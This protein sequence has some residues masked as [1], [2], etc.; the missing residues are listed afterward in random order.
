MKK[1]NYALQW[2]LW[3]D[4]TYYKASCIKDVVHN[5]N[6]L[7]CLIYNKS[8]N[9]CDT[10]CLSLA[11]KDLHV[12]DRQRENNGKCQLI[13]ANNVSTL[14]EKRDLLACLNK[15]FYFGL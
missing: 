5:I 12:E 7:V 10:N 6:L 11:A 2:I 14:L 4:D 13:I 15:E 3:W 1:R 9:S 8:L